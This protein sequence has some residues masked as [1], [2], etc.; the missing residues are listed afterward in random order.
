M[1]ERSRMEPLA[2]LVR[3]IMSNI[4]D[5]PEEEKAWGS[6]TN[7]VEHKNETLALRFVPAYLF[8]YY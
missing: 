6:R 3:I 8:L 1:L 7:F 4:D 5:P 2:G